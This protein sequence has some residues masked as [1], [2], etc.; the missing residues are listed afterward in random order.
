M[1]LDADGSYPPEVGASKK[2]QPASRGSMVDARKAL[3]RGQETGQTQ[4]VQRPKSGGFG[5]QSTE[6]VQ[7][8]WIR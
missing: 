2:H 4:A 5:G 3:R 8:F 1:L 6:T 7:S